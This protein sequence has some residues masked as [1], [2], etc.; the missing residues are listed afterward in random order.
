MGFAHLPASNLFLPGETQAA[1]TKASPDSSARPKYPGRKNCGAAFKMEVPASPKSLLS[2]KVSPTLAKLC[3]Q[4]DA[5]LVQLFASDQAFNYIFSQLSSQDNAG[6]R[7]AK[8]PS[9][10]EI[11]SLQ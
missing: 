4:E 1:V 6:I 7:R 9:S 2:D 10:P 3:N 8:C 11:L 5:G